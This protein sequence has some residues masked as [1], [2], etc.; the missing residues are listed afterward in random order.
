MCG[1]PG[2][3]SMSLPCLPRR[4]PGELPAGPFSLQGMSLCGDVHGG[5]PASVVT[6]GRR[7]RASRNGRR[8]CRR[9]RSAGGHGRVLRALRA[10]PRPSALRATP[11]ISGRGPAV[12]REGQL[13]TGS[14]SFAPGPQGISSTC[15]FWRPLVCVPMT[16][17]SELVA[18]VVLTG[19]RGILAVPHGCTCAAQGELLPSFDS[20][21]G[22]GH[23]WHARSRASGRPAPSG[24]AL[25][26]AWTA[27]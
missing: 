12:T 20:L 17:V 11:P 24:P 19:P 5:R 18:S 27:A 2:Q 13:S 4:T 3:R 21:A 8:M 22:A 7:L 14:C 16:G 6:T 1:V 23:P 10:A 25:S 15:L 9:A 26:R